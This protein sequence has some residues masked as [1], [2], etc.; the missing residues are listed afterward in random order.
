MPSGPG[1]V[2]RP[3]QPRPPLPPTRCGD[4]AVPRR[5]RTGHARA[6]SCGRAVTSRDGGEPAVTEDRGQ[7]PP[8]LRRG[9]ALPSLPPRAPVP[10]L[11]SPLRFSPPG[12]IGRILTHQPPTS[13]ALQASTTPR[14]ALEW[15]RRPLPSRAPNTQR[16]YAVGARYCNFLG[17]PRHHLACVSDEQVGGFACF[18]LRGMDDLLAEHGVPP[19]SCPRVSAAST[20][21]NYIAVVPALYEERGW[22][23]SVSELR[24]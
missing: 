13:Q 20:V 16:T 8:A 6:D 18:L 3:G 21:N 24:R 4:R 12:F 2:N 17:F 23:C 9:A 10:C 19:A 7:M 1:S 11:P 22:V 15:T 14:F 5:T